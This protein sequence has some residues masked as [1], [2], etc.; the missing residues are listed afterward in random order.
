[1][2]F[3]ASNFL[4]AV[5]DGKQQVRWWVLYLLTFLLGVGFG[6]VVF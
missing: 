3:T 6:V 1:M 5:K 4:V 2:P